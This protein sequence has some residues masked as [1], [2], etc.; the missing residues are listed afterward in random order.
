MPHKVIYSRFFLERVYSWN[1]ALQD[2]AFRAAEHAAIDPNHTDYSRGYLTPYKQKHPT[3][4]HQYTLYFEIINTPT[5]I[6]VCWINDDTC[7]HDTRMSYGDDPCLKE[8]K[9][10]QARNNLET[11]DPKFHQIQFEVQPDNKK[12]FRCRSRYLGHEVQANTS[13]DAAGTFLAHSF[14]STEPHQDIGKIHIEL[15]L[16]ELHKHISQNTVPFEFCIFKTGNHVQIDQ[17][18]KFHDATKW[19]IVDDPDDFIMRPI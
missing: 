14:N 12:P 2:M 13:K 5:S 6:F 1:Q 4:D 10:T 18:T 8:F 16:N 7:L 11:Y 19:K 17:L 3:S 9:K 15:F